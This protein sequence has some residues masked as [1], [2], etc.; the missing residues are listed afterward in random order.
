MKAEL[1]IYQQNFKKNRVK[2]WE[3]YKAH[4]IKILNDAF[5]NY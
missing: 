1:F 2:Q 3:F 5:A 4:I